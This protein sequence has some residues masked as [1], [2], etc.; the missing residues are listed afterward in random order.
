LSTFSLFHQAHLS[1]WSGA[2]DWNSDSVV[3]TMHTS[4]YVP[5]LDTHAHV[6][7]LSNEVPAGA[8]YST[9]G[10]LL[11]GKGAAYLPAGSWPDAWQP[12]SA[13]SLGQIVRPVLSP[14]LIFRCVVAGTSGS[15]A[16]AWPVTTGLTVTDGG[17]TWLA[18][19]SGA[20]V[21]TAAN[22]QWFSFTATFRYIVLSDRTPALATAQ[23]LIA[24][25]DMG[26]NVS[27][28]GGN[29]DVLFD[30]ASGSGIVIPLWA[31]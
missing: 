12:V 15:V 8:G 26:G 9:G 18:I 22:L 24:L 5:N 30:S 17:A 2:I 25:A 13:Y 1:A 10:L 16:P 31:P 20:V 19:A 4:S 11:S 29:F 23:P 3:A 6:S 14:A 7:D 27:G 21:L 28:S